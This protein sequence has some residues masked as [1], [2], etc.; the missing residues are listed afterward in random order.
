MSS[1]TI[2]IVDNT[3]G[4]ETLEEMVRQLGHHAVAATTV[5]EGLAVCRSLQPAL[6][7]LNLDLSDLDGLEI[8]GNLRAE[9][10]DCPVIVRSDFGYISLVVSAMKGG[11]NH[12]LASPVN[13]VELKEAIETALERPPSR[14]EISPPRKRLSR[15]QQPHPAEHQSFY[16]NSDKMKA[17]Q[18]IIEQVADTNATILIRG[19]SGV[20]KELVAQ[21]I[22]YASPRRDKPF[23]KVNC[24]ALPTELLESEL[25]GHEKGAF[26]GAYYRK[27]GK[28]EFANH[29]TIFLDEIGDLPL[30]LQ[31]KLLHVLQDSE[32]SRIGGRETIKVNIRV[33]AATNKDL[34]EGV[35]NGQ[36]RQDLYYR[37]NVVNI[38][39]PQLRDRQEEIPLLANFFLQ[40]FNTQYNRKAAISSDTMHLL[41]SYEWPGNVRELENMVKR[42]VVLENEKVVQQELLK[43]PRP[44][45]GE[46]PNPRLE[47]SGSTTTE[48]NLKEIARHAAREAEHTTIKKVLERVNGNRAEAARVLK[49]SY[50]AL[51]YK[52]DQCGLGSKRAKPPV[53]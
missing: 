38:F 45:G 11:A 53:G 26:T 25:F 31:A 14:P 30:G 1:Y 42:L 9:S 4:C 48:L 35:K 28:F 8:I 21:A 50:K 10:G 18:E 43:H 49:I 17:V 34:E 6:I 44:T 24:A 13:P 22:H 3:E 29:G 7:L 23:I 32:F 12:F 37:V 5:N 40:K 47:T 20:G 52:I 15:G 16:V 36:F 27:P 41:S 51:L 46:P 39:V 2:L 33:I 19:E